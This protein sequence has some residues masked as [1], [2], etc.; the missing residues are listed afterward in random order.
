MPSRLDLGGPSRGQVLGVAMEMVETRHA[1]DDAAAF[2]DAEWRACAG[3][4]DPA[5]ALAAR[6]AA[7]E[8]F[9]KAIHGAAPALDLREV[10]IVRQ[11]RD[12]AD[13]ALH[14]AAAEQARALGIRRAHVRLQHLHGLAAAIVVLEA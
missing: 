7:K 11:R 1:A 13:V 10:E 12:R 5:R 14:G 6:L 8:A 9:R 3:R 2:T 4:R